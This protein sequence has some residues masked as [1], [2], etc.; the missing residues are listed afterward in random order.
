MQLKESGAAVFKPAKARSTDPLPEDAVSELARAL[1]RL[2][3]EL[4]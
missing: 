2:N 4:N 1:R 3:G